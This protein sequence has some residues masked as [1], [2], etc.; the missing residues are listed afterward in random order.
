MQEIQKIERRQFHAEMKAMANDPMFIENHTLQYF[1]FLVRK[2]NSIINDPIPE[3]DTDQY[4]NQVAKL[5]AIVGE[6]ERIHQKKAQDLK[7]RKAE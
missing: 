7:F 5:H 4:I 2:G 6:K 3:D 1:Q